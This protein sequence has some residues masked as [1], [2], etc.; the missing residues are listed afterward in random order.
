MM[1]TGMRPVALPWDNVTFEPSP[2]GS[3]RVRNAAL[4][5][6]YPGR[7]TERLGHWADIAPNRVFLASAL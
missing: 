2:D 5:G 1:K 4:L 6:A 7:L 3:L